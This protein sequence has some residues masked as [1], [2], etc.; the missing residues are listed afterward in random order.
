MEKSP[1]VFLAGQGE[2]RFDIFQSILF[3]QIKP[4]LRRSYVTK[5]RTPEVSLTSNWHAGRETS[6]PVDSSLEEGK[7]STQ[8]VHFC[9]VVLFCF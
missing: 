4:A 7:H 9:F 8:L 6:T 5:A 2:N 1:L 3:L